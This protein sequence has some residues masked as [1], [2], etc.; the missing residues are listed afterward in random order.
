MNSRLAMAYS[1]RGIVKITLGDQDGGCLD[2][3][4]SAELGN[5]QA[6]ILMRKFCQ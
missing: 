3:E 6:L 1:N 2:L 5:S 4:T